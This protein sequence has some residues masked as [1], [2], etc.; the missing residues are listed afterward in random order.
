MRNYLWLLGLPFVLS[1]AAGDVLLLSYFK[2]NGEAGVYLAGSRDGRSF[3]E[4]NGGRPVMAPPAWPGQN[5][6]RDPSILFRDGKFRMTWTSSWKG[7]Q[8]GYA[9]S[10][11]LQAWSEPVAVKPFAAITVA[12]DRPLNVWAP[13][14]SWNPATA[15]YL[16]LWSTTT[17]RELADGDNP[18]A[19]NLDHR[20]YSCTTRDGRTFSPARLFYDPGHSVIDAFPCYD[21]R[22]TPDAADDRWIVVAKNE[23]DVKDGGKNI[24]RLVA[25][26]DLAGPLPPLSAPLLGPGAALRGQEMQEGPSLLRFGGEWLLYADAFANKHYTLIVSKDGETWRDETEKLK[27]PSGTRH[28]TVFVV[29]SAA[30]APGLW[31]Q[32]DSR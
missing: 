23:Q 19:H 11:D 30:L 14:I 1:A 7:D 20:I 6:T 2:G 3:T 15:E 32:T 18:I 28:G 31:P 17:P 4:L 29:P 24:R 21:D 12:E 16:I 5:L 13:E 9:E 22:G 27:V 8:F 26:R 10:A 25:S